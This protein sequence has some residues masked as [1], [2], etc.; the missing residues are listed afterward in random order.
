[1]KFLKSLAAAGLCLA[2][3][4]CSLF[5]EKPEGPDGSKQGAEAP[6][7]V[8][9]EVASDIDK[10]AHGHASDAEMDQAELVRRLAAAIAPGP[11][12]K[13]PAP[14]SVPGAALAS[15][16]SATLPA[17]A[18]GAPVKPE[19]PIAATAE[20]GAPPVPE[21]QGGTPP[22]AA[23]RGK[24]GGRTE[25]YRVRRGDTMMKIAFAKL[26]DLRRWREIY[27]DN[28]RALRDFNL[29]Y[30]GMTLVIHGVEYVVIEKNGEPYLIRKSDTL[31]RISNKVYGTPKKWRDLWH[32]NPRLI[33]D[34][35]KIYA[36]FTLYYRAQAEAA[37]LAS[38]AGATNSPAAPATDAAGAP[39]PASSSAET[40][41]PAPSAS[42]GGAEAQAEGGADG[43]SPREPATAVAPGA[44][45]PA[46]AAEAAPTEAAPSAAPAPAPES[47]EP[48]AVE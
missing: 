1:L 36:G 35:N 4:G 31:A 34:P 33:P 7:A 5:S 42:Q 3:T 26:G 18:P 16:L 30:P 43:G 32:N 23:R 8:P 25:R 46:P 22:P 19:P 13:G 9:A 12:Q 28:R 44:A 41:A 21:E 47:P 29:V 48:P 37:P 17:G 38:A 27:N 39:A 14:A 20:G 15:P 24:M 11:G 40:Q 10:I 2:A 45:A 6:K